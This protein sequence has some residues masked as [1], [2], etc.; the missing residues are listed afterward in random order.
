MQIRLRGAGYQQEPA[1]MR[2]PWWLYAMLV[3]GILLTLAS[4]AGHVWQFVG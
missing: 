2:D 4:M 3:A 1:M